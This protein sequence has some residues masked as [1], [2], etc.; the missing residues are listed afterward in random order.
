MY[1]DQASTTD[2][3]A[4]AVASALDHFVRE[5]IMDKYYALDISDPR[6]NKSTVCL[7]PILV[8]DFL[9]SADDSQIIKCI[10]KDGRRVDVYIPPIQ[11][12]EVNP[13]WVIIGPHVLGQG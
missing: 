2:A 12:R 9:L 3:S 5:A 11:V 1:F 6:G 7:R 4:I 13:A 8:Q 10:D